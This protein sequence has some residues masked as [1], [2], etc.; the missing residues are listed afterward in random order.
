MIHLG[1]K[2]QKINDVLKSK[3]YKPLV[4]RTVDHRTSPGHS[5]ESTLPSPSFSLIGTTSFENNSTLSESSLSCETS[6]GDDLNTTSQNLGQV[7]EQSTFLA[8]INAT[9]GNG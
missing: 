7:T 1:W 9:P 8:Q 6:S 5:N 4:L 2:H 3:G